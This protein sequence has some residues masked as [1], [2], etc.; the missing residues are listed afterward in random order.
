MGEIISSLRDRQLHTQNVPLKPVLRKATRR[1]RENYAQNRELAKSAI[2][3]CQQAIQRLNLQMNLISCEYTLD[4]SKIIFIYV[5]DE[6][7]DFRELLKELAAMFKCRIELRQIGPRDKAKIIGGL[8]TCG[9]ETCCSRLIDIRIGRFD[10]HGQKSAAGTEHSETVRT[11]R[12][13]DVL[14]E[15]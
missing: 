6:R 5:A 11:V 1:D 8:G 13:A 9:M 7:V 3:Q 10:Q 14:S 12:Q 15:I 4:R 2:V